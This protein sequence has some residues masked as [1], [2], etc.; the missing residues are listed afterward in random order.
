VIG[1]KKPP[2]ITNISFSHHGNE[3]TA[4]K[5]IKLVDGFLDHQPT[6]SK[7]NSHSFALSFV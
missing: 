4:E 3:K 1:R 5:M 2:T 6:N 7:V